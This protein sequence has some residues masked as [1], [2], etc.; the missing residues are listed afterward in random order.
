MQSF[1]LYGCLRLALGLNILLQRDKELSQPVLGISLCSGI[2]DL[3]LGP[4]VYFLFCLSVMHDTTSGQPTAISALWEGRR[5]CCSTRRVCA[6]RMGF[7]G[8]VLTIE[9]DLAL[10]LLQV[11]KVVLT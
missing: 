7:G 9:V 3:V 6:C 4:D 11:R 1:N 10:A 5:L 2:F 8:L